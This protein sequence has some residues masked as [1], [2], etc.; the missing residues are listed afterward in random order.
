VKTISLLALGGLILAAPASAQSGA[1]APAGDFGGLW[2]P[3]TGANRD[4]MRAETAPPPAAQPVRGPLA[5]GSASLGE[6]V[7]EMVRLGDCEG[8]ERLARE[9]GDFPLVEAVRGHCRRAVPASSRVQVQQP[10]RP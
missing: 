1:P 10:Q 6:R 9:A 8:G 2:T 5:A 3:W 7:G 4:A